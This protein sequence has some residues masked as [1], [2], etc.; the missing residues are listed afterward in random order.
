MQYQ[1]IYL[2][3][4]LFIFNKLTQNMDFLNKYCF[5]YSFYLDES[6]DNNTKIKWR[7]IPVH[8]LQTIYRKLELNKVLDHE[9]DER[10]SPIDE[11]CVE[12]LRYECDVRGLDSRG[13]KK[14]LV[15]ILKEKLGQY[16]KVA[17]HNKNTSV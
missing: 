7:S 6:D 8:D 2:C 5:Y 10:N 17:N 12:Q 14:V 4:C 9:F 13:Y 3:R 16:A 11:L 15:S 1:I